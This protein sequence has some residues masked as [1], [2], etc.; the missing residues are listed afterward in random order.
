MFSKIHNKSA[1]RVNCY[2]LLQDTFSNHLD[3]TN[4]FSTYPLVLLQPNLLHSVILPLEPETP[5]DQD[6]NGIFGEFHEQS[7]GLSVVPN[8]QQPEPEM[9]GFGS[10]SGAPLGA[11]KNKVEL[12]MP[13]YGEPEE[14]DSFG[15]FVDI[16]LGSPHFTLTRTPKAASGK[17]SNTFVEQDSSQVKLLRT[18]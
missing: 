16:D 11:K 14:V 6:I 17:W 9:Y 1:I 15:D 12:F 8:I 7:S 10:S 2:F 13:Q 18:N 4:P 3:T 5:S